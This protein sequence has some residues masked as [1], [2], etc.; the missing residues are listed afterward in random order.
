M[1]RRHRCSDYLSAAES[2]SG[3]Q[4]PDSADTGFLDL[5]A[6]RINISLVIRELLLELG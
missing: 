5:P 3:A 6:E 2:A 1:L 4:Q